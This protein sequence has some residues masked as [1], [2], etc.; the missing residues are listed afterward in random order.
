M[1]KSNVLLSFEKFRDFKPTIT[2]I[3]TANDMTAITSLPL[4]KPVK[5]PA[6]LLTVLK[7]A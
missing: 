5:D 7:G 6:F 2:K 1:K 3:G 4:Q